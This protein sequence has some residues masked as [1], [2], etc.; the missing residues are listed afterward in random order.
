MEKEIEK[1]I[2]SEK[3]N[4]QKQKKEKVKKIQPEETL[5]TALVEKYSDM[6]SSKN[7]LYYISIVLVNFAILALSMLWL[8]NKYSVVSFEAIKLNFDFTYVLLMC[9]VFVLIKMIQTVSLFIS[10]HFKSRVN[11]FGRMYIANAYSDFYGGMTMF[12][13]GK[14]TALVGALSSTKIKPQHLISV[15]YEKK[16]YNLF[17]FLTVSAV[18][19]IV[20]AFTWES[21]LHVLA[22]LTCFITIICGFMYLVY[23]RMTRSD[24]ERGLS[25]C[26][27][28]ARLLAKIGIAK[29]FEKT[30]YA[31][32]DKTMITAKANRVKWKAKLLNM[33][34]ALGVIALRAFIVYLIFS[35]LGLSTVGY[36]FKSLWILLVLDLITMIWPLPRGVVI[37]DILIISIISKMLY[38]DYI[39]Y[40]LVF[41]KLFENIIYALHYVI[42]LIVDKITSI[43]RNKKQIKRVCL[44][45]RLFLPND[46]SP[47]YEWFPLPT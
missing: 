2:A 44:C 25:I 6:H 35:S 24:K 1:D 31:M 15:T 17:T 23:I 32:V 29:D 28:I 18:M 30:Y 40:V 38:P 45:G 3:I 16:Y 47:A 11:N 14:T 21:I 9:C 13:S 7:A 5:H 26:S 22:T 41:Y 39:W 43:I 27:F 36:Y 12:A 34:A 10:Y 42:V 46:L 37:I 8:N 20:G 33:G 19:I 4:K